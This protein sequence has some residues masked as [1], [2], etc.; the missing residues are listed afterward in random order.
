[1]TQKMCEDFVKIFF[2]KKIFF[3][4]KNIIIKLNLLKYN[5]IIQVL[6]INRNKNNNI[7]NKIII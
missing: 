1:M 3:R 5:Y 7:K 6:Y 2:D 4:Y